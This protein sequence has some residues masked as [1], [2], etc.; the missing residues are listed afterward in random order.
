MVELGGRRSTSRNWSLSWCGANSETDPEKGR[1]FVCGERF[2]EGKTLSKRNKVRVKINLERLKEDD[3]H[4]TDV[5]KRL[6]NIAGKTDYI[7]LRQGGYFE[8]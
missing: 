3:V 2:K 7:N 5:Q 8:T 1:F 6:D 4:K